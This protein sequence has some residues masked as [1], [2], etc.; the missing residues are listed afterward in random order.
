MKKIVYLLCCAIF[1]AS[2]NTS[3]VY[4]PKNINS[5]DRPFAIETMQKIITALD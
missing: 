5:N 3:R 1:L 2:C 4:D